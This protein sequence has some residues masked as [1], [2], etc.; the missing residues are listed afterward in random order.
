MS[1]TSCG[2]TRFNRHSCT[3]ANLKVP[4]MII[5]EVDGDKGSWH[6]NISSAQHRWYDLWHYIYCVVQSRENFTVEKINT[7]THTRSP[8]ID[9][10]INIKM[11]TLYWSVANLKQAISLKSV[12]RKSTRITSDEFDLVTKDA[13]K[14]VSL[15]SILANMLCFCICPIFLLMSEKLVF[16]CKKCGF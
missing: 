14:N 16:L 3:V 8:Y 4:A 11:R 7:H 10:N 1:F 2:S 9:H 15:K 13:Y 12:S 6:R 5:Y